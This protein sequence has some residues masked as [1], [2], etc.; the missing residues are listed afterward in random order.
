MFCTAASS[1]TLIAGPTILQAHGITTNQG[2]VNLAGRDV[3]VNVYNHYHSYPDNVD[4]GAVLSAI[5]NMRVMHLD[6]LSKATPGTG[7]WFFKAPMFV[8]WLDPNGCVKVLWGTGIREWN[9]TVVPEP[10]T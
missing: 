10:L 7:I 9:L 6:N 5:R 2:D 3:N 4:I 8:T 1:I